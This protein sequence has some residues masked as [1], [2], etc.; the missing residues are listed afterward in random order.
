MKKRIR[1]FALVLIAAFAAA[2]LCSCTETKPPVEGG[3]GET[4][5]GDNGQVYTV[6]L[7]STFPAGNVNFEV[8]KVLC[9]K[10]SEVTGGEL[11]FNLLGGSEIFAGT[12]GAEAVMNGALDAVY[13]AADY[14]NGFIP[15]TAAICASNMTNAEMT[16]S[17]GIDYL[18]GL[19][20]DSGIRLLFVVDEVGISGTQIFTKAVVNSL[21][22]LKDMNIRSAGTVSVDILTAIGCTATPLNLAD[23]FPSLEQNLVDGYVGPAY[24]GGGEGF[25]EYVK[26]VVDTEIARGGSSLWINTSTWEEIPEEIRSLFME[27]IEEINAAMVDVYREY[28]ENNH[29]AIQE[30]GGQIITLDQA[31][32]ETLQEVS[33]DSAWKSVEDKVDADTYETLKELFVK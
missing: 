5:P 29:A 32:Q 14:I 20:S 4:T 7:V 21:D 11:Q 2:L 16:S 25:F 22:E 23:V 15:E 27:N 26:C 6:D 9:E 12:A 13:T 24:L 1:G 8:C 3:D 28:V 18:N 31:D 30:A 10:A 19:M 17:G 33:Q